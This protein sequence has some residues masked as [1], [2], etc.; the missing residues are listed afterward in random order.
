VVL[1]YRSVVHDQ[2]QGKIRPPNNPDIGDDEEVVRVSL[3]SYGGEVLSRDVRGREE[4][5]KIPDFIVVKATGSLA[6]PPPQS[7]IYDAIHHST[8]QMEILY[9]ICFTSGCA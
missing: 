1:P 3:D 7:S 9:C 8:P 2:P 4:S 5:V 6:L